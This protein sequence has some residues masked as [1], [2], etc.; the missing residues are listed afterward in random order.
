[1]MDM[2]DHL[3]LNKY[4]VRA[5]LGMIKTAKKAIKMNTQD[6]LAKLKPEIE[7]YKASKDY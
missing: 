6:E 7:Q 1:M 2:E 4:A 3:Y 5:A